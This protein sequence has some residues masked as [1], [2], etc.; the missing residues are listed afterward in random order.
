MVGERDQQTS[1]VLGAA[2]EVHRPLG[3]GFLEAVYQRALCVELGSR[4]VPHVS[5]A[6][7][8]VRYKGQELGCGYRADVICWPEEDPVLLELKALAR[9]TDIERA[10]I[11]HYL[12][13]TGIR[14]GLLLNFGAERLEGQR[15][16][17]G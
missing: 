4:D 5:E 2:I 1:A 11:L 16:V 15:L 7:V 10:Q 13:A 6:P 8:A 9:L 17:N 12:R 3:R 14:R